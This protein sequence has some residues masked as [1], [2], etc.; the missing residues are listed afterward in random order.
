[1]R[2]IPAR[3]NARPPVWRRMGGRSFLTA[4]W[5]RAPKVIRV[6][7]HSGDRGRSPSRVATDGRAVVLDR[8][9][10]A[11]DKGRSRYATFRRPRTVALP[12]DD[13][14]EGGRPRPPSSCVRQRSLAMRDIPARRNARPPVWR[15][16]GGRSFLTAMWLRA[17]K[18]VRVTR[19]SGDRGRAPSRVATD[20]RAVFLDRRVV[21]SDKGR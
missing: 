20:G 8:R 19:H 6:T 10:V 4:T 1:M 15:R 16:M 9:V 21:A 5:L 18:V 3:R 11:S 17:P 7:R 2:D 13:R 14:W 12:C